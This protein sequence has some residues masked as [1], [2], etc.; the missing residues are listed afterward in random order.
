MPKSVKIGQKLKNT[1]GIL[2]TKST[3]MRDFGE[4]GQRILFWCQCPSSGSKSPILLSANHNGGFQRGRY[5]V[6]NLSTS[7]YIRIVHTQPVFITDYCLQ[8]TTRPKFLLHFV[9]FFHVA[10]LLFTGVDKEKVGVDNEKALELKNSPVFYRGIQW[11]SSRAGE[12]NI[13]FTF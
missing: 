12:Q 3:R 13:F 5:I 10:S 1:T 7:K 6:T 11:K 4:R 2:W 9:A 8:F